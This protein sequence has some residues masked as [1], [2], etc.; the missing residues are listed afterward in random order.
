[1][2]KGNALWK[3][4]VPALL[5][6]AL[7]FT[8]CYS[9]ERQPVDFVA[10]VNGTTYTQEDYDAWYKDAS[11]FE[12]T[13]DTDL[14][15]MIGM[16]G[17]FAD[18][19]PLLVFTRYLAICDAEGGTVSEA[20]ARAALE[21]LGVEENEQ[22][23]R[24]AVMYETIRRCKEKYVADVR[25]DEEGARAWYETHLEEQRAYAQENPGRACARYLSSYYPVTLYIPAGMKLY[26]AM[27][28]GYNGSDES[29]TFA[30]SQEAWRKLIVGTDFNEVFRQFNTAERY[31]D[32]GKPKTILTYPGWNEDPS[33]LLSVQNIED[34]GQMCSPTKCTDGFVIARYLGEAKSGEIA[35]EEVQD[36]CLGAELRERQDKAWQEAIFQIEQ[37]ARIRYAS[38]KKE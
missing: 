16:E 35:F 15:G 31:D 1:M 6:A 26:Q 10:I 12:E 20:D 37:D 4:L 23:I 34:V 24:C 18:E 8:G 13:L 5:L 27:E 2:R 38:T 36:Y 25:E 21:S 7:F 19:M 3:K 9:E 11:R 28:I 14:M 17:S 30:R 33:L 29:T 22:S 32:G